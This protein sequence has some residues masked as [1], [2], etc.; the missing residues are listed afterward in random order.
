[1]KDTGGYA[2][3]CDM[4]PGM[5]F[6]VRSNRLALTFVGVDPVQSQRATSRRWVRVLTEEGP[7]WVCDKWERFPLVAEEER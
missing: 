1:M 4:E 2:R 7:S 6:R 3:V 5:H